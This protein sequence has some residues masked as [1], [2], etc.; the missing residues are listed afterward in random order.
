MV[1]VVLH[2]PHRQHV[3]RERKKN[4]AVHSRGE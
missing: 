2:D 3:E 4:N 1:V